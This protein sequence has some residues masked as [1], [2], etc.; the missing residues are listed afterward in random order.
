MSKPNHV[1]D[2]VVLGGGPGGY[3]AAIRAAQLQMKTALIERDRVGGVCLN[4]GCIPTK[5]LLRNAEIYHLF[6]RSKDFGLRYENLQ[7]DFSNVVQRSRQVAD[8][9]VKGVEFLLKKNDVALFTGTGRFV[10][11]G[12]IGVFDPDGKPT[13]RISFKQAVIATGARPRSIPGLDI[14]RKKILTSTEAMVL[15]NVPASMLIVGAGGIGVEFAYLYSTF[16]TKVTL[17][18]MMPHILPLED[19]E[20]V[21][22]VAKRFIKAKIEIFTNT[23]VEGSE[24]T[25]EGVVV[26]ASTPDGPIER[27]GEVVLVA[28]GVQG[29]SDGIGLEESGIAVDKRFVVVDK[30][31]YRT[32]IEGIYAVGDVIGP[33]LLAHVATAE[34]IAA[35]EGIAGLREE[36]VDYSTI[37]R[38]TYCQPQVASVGLTEEQAVEAGHEVKVG[39]FP[40][41]ASGKSLAIGEHEGFVK[42]IFD[43]RYGELLGAHIVGSEATEM[44]AELCTAKTLETTY[45]ELLRTVHAHPTLAEAIMEA[46]GEAFGEAIHI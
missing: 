22:V 31:T 24:V 34:G 43:A 2:V 27:K 9:L 13:D 39:R 23:R 5:A 42:L 44:I 33:P 7:V 30:S 15:E 41:R 19:N 26:R 37:P 4:W 20:V 3:V 32:N 28:V 40:F 18:E 11:P 1:C 25:D 16:G 38:C 8:R 6:K 12:E 45:L 14:D 36:G 21:E 29:N 10:A 17:M 35:V 46:A